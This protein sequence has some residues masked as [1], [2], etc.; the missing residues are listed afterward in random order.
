MDNEDIDVGKLSD[1]EIL[2]LLAHGHRDMHSAIKGHSER[3]QKLEDF[4]LMLAGA[5]TI[6][7]ALGAVIWSK[8][9]NK[10]H[11]GAP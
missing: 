9:E 7:A 3:I 8:I 6:A 5:G 11:I 10:F 2:V 1:R 4:R